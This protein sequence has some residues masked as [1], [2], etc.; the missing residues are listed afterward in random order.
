LLVGLSPYYFWSIC[1]SSFVAFRSWRISFLSVIAQALLLLYLVCVQVRI[2]FLLLVTPMRVVS[3]RSRSMRVGF[4][5]RTHMCRS[6]NERHSL[7]GWRVCAWLWGINHFHKNSELSFEA[8]F[9]DSS[10]VNSNTWHLICIFHRWYCIFHRWYC[11]FHMLCLCSLTSSR[12]PRY[13]LGRQT[14][15]SWG[16]YV[17]IGTRARLR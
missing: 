1:M 12:I 17:T 9:C 3:G 5:T 8:I 10:F 15:H 16:N 2:F 13:D 11:I 14:P 7:L 4:P 6:S